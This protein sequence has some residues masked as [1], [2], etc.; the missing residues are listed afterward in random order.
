MRDYFGNFEVHVTVAVTGSLDTF[1]HWCQA[2][3]CKCVWIVLA[4]GVEV[5]HPMATWRRSGTVLPDVLAEAKQRVEALQREGFVV[6]RLKIE[7]DISND[8]VPETDDAARLEPASCYFEHHVKL[9]R[10]VTAGCESLTQ[11]SLSHAAHLSRNAWRKPIE[12]VEERFVTLRSHRVGRLTSAQQLDGLLMDLKSAG[13]QIA[14]VES[15]Y[16]VY[17]SN[18]ALDDGWLPLAV[19]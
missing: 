12:G 18:L 10:D 1:R 3:P 14:D 7:A 15:E 4:R 17:D 6:A 9:R 2:E 5:Q 11:V 8:Q 19:R 13:E 16:A